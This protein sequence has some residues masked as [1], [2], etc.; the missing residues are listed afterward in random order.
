MPGRGQLTSVCKGFLEA[1]VT[2]RLQVQG[3]G[4]SASGLM[5][6][7]KAVSERGN[8]SASQAQST[9]VWAWTTQARTTPVWLLCFRG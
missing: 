9:P 2:F 1:L 7:Q 8:R 3:Q 5:A 4:R 6:T